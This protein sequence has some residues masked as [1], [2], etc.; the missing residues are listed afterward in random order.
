M[1]FRALIAVNCSSRTTAD[2]RLYVQLPLVFR[3]VI[4]E[5]LSNAYTATNVMCVS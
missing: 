3:S 2:G 1:L 4:P 5:Q